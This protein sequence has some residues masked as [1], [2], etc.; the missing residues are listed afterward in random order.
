M[1]V[2][3]IEITGRFRVFDIASGEYIYSNLSRSAPGDIP[4]DVACLPVV[5]LRMFDDVLY[6]DTM[7]K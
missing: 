3:D 5:G 4:P 7:I 6:I 1:I 2:N